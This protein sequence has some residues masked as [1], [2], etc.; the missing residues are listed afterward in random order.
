MDSTGF[1]KDYDGY[2]GAAWDNATARECI[3]LLA[4]Q[5]E[6]RDGLW[7]RGAKVYCVDNHTSLSLS[8]TELKADKTAKEGENKEHKA[9]ERNLVSPPLQSFQ[10]VFAAQPGPQVFGAC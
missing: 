1:E 7:K 10:D 9:L 2:A 4:A 3:L 6:T 8:Q 5:T